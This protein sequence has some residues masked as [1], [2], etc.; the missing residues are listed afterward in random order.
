[1]KNLVN[2]TASQPEVKGEREQEVSQLR[3][4]RFEKSTIKTQKN[5]IDVILETQES[6]SEIGGVCLAAVACK[7][8]LEARS[9]M[10]PS[11]F[12]I[13]LRCCSGCGFF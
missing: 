1:M 4:H 6:K 8:G 5:N 13:R 11:K 3:G 9:G 7:S 2:M 12:H 10:V